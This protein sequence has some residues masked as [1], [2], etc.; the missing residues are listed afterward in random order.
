VLIARDLARAFD[1]S[2]L[3]RDARIVLDKWQVDLLNSASERILALAPRQ[4]GKTEAVVWRCI[5]QALYDPGLIVIASPSLNQSAEF[6]KRFMNRY[7][8]LDGVPD[9]TAESVLRCELSNG[10]RIRCFPGSEKSVRG[11]ASVK[12]CFVDEA[13]RVD[14]DLFVALKPMLAVTRGTLV[15]CSTPCGRRGQF[16]KTWSEGDNWE[17]IKIT[18][19]QCPRLSPSVLADQLRE[20][21]PSMYAQEFGLE[22]IDGTEAVF[23]HEIISGAFS[24]EV[25]PLWQ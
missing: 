15:M 23:S 24:D 20:L 14:D 18:T 3:A 19:D 25:Q 17:R 11:F 16:F 6:F 7:R 13:A 2:L 10:A 12:L 1:P 5:R 22:F 8:S 4:S 21:G 9:V